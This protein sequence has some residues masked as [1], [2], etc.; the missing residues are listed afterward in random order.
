MPLHFSSVF[1]A[2]IL[3]KNFLKPV[4]CKKNISNF[5]LTLAWDNYL[6]IIN[7]F[8]QHACLQKYFFI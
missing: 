7:I 2:T 6:L 8:Q 3:W 5:L 4:T 1:T